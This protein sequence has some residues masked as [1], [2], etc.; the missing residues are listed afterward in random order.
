MPKKVYLRVYLHIFF[1]MFYFP[2]HWLIGVLLWWHRDDLFLV[3][4]WLQLVSSLIIQF[5]LQGSVDSI[6]AHYNNNVEGEKLFFLQ[7]VEHRDMIHF[8][9]KV[10]IWRSALQVAVFSEI[11]PVY[12]TGL[13]FF[14][15]LLCIFAHYDWW[16]LMW[17][18]VVTLPVSYFSS[19]WA[20]EYLC[21]E[22]TG[23][24]HKHPSVFNHFFT[25]IKREKIRMQA[26]QRM[27]EK[28]QKERNRNKPIAKSNSRTKNPPKKPY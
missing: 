21:S 25:V 14:Y 26:Q 10:L 24:M 11:I 2:T 15:L 1:A 7:N 13:F 6:L 22:E 8:M 12:K 9:D 16:N 27:M 17:V 3:P 5:C 4:D 19:A 28:L 23:L 20:S 18:A